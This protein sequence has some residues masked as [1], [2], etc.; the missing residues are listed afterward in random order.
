MNAFWGMDTAQVREH[1]GRLRTASGEVEDLTAR[2][3]SAVQGASWAG[4]DAEEFRGRWASLAK[5]RLA[6][7]RAEL[8]ALSDGALGEADQQDVVSTPD[9]T[10]AGPGG[11]PSTIPPSDASGSSSGYRQED[12]PWIPNWLENPVEGAVSD[13]A[14]MVSAGIGQGFDT[15]IDLLEGGLGLFGVN[16][17]GIAQFQLDGDHFGD[18]L[19]DWATGERVPTIAEVGAAGLLSV[20]SAGV[21]IYEA[22][23]GQ[24]TALFDD[25]PGGIVESVA[26][27]SDPAQSPQTLQDLI[28]QN[29]ALRMENPGGP[30]QNGQIGIQ[31]IRSA[32]SDEPV[33]IV[34]V[35]PTEGADISDVP[36]AY[37]GQGNSRDWGS[38]LRLTAG[39]H[40]AAMDD[41]QAAM[42]AAGVPP[43]AD[44]MIVGH[45]QGGIVANH[46][47]ADPSFNSASGEAGT[48][49][50]T[51]AFS[52]GSP[53]QTVVPAQGSTQSVNVSHEGGIG[54]GG[55]SGDL[56]PGL[57]LG[58]AQVDG[59]TL[60]VPN[61]HEV[62]L[63]GYPVDSL[64][65]VKILE[66]NHDSV[67]LQGQA[68]GGYSGSVGRTTATDPTLSALQDDLT[69]RYLGDGTYVAESHVVSV[70]RGAP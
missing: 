57:D 67:G 7:V 66:S 60:G 24:D 61:R 70:G 42:E 16:T 35:P 58:G 49:N 33:Y 55:I 30:L 41:V 26:T 8:L 37:G 25:R 64:N 69:G 31:E 14:G 11:D 65:P 56:I 6:A 2:L 4:A 39:Q 23:T 59:G 48:Y 52:V 1:A 13:L 44:V 12:N 47:T 32:S 54:A 45:S 27:D 9:G 20:G 50:V 5:D 22:A 17:D 28:L 62:S 68:E 63:P 46:L 38:N 3:T 53:V 15:G 51:H 34:Q 21:G 10:Y 29:D 19:E 40:P 36:G 18:I 43:G